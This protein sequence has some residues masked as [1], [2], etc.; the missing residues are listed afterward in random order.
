MPRAAFWT[1]KGKYFWPLDSATLAHMRQEFAWL[2]VRKRKD[3][4]EA[5]IEFITDAKFGDPSIGGDHPRQAAYDY[6]LVYGC[7]AWGKLE[8]ITPH[9][10]G[11]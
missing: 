7:P 4:D 8:A 1:T 5:L 11:E 9:K 2:Y 10:K 6:E 3:R